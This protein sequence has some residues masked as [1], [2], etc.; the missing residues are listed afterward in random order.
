MIFNDYKCTKKIFFYYKACNFINFVNNFEKITVN[1]KVI[2]RKSTPHDVDAIMSCYDIARNYMRAE[3]NYIQWTNGYPSRQLVMNDITREVSYV[4]TDEGNNVVMAFAFIIGDDPTYSVIED[5]EWLNEEPYGTIHRLGSNGKHKGIL[6]QCVDFCSSKIGNIRL[7]TH[8]DNV[9]M[10]R[11]AEKLDFTRCG[12]IYTD[13][14]TPR[15]AYQKCN[16]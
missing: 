12:I 14:G 11:A 13:D 7:D 16:F 4:G 2:I 6:K 5:G 10:Q 8:A 1:D 15:I 9:T 3:G